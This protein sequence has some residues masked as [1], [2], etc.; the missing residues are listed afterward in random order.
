MKGIVKLKDVKINDTKAITNILNKIEDDTVDEVN[1]FKASL[2]KASI[3][4]AI[5]LNICF[6]RAMKIC[7]PMLTS[8]KAQI[9]EEYP[10]QTFADRVTPNIVKKKTTKKSS[11]NDF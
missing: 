11:K 6:D 3:K 7:T 1:L 9:D 5:P 10:I 8:I 4:S 2:E